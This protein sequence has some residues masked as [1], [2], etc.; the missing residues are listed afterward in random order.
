[1]ASTDLDDVLWHDAMLSRFWLCI[2]CPLSSQPWLQMHLLNGLDLFQYKSEAVNFV[3]CRLCL[4]GT[5]HMTY[6]NR[7]SGSVFSTHT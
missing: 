4:A 1:M 6:R 5:Q 7:V 3:Q 2:H